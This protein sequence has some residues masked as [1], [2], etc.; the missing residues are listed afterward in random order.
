VRLARPQHLPRLI[1]WPTS[2]YCLDLCRLY[3]HLASRMQ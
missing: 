3:H 1:K 2:D